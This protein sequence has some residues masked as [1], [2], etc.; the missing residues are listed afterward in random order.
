M[1][2]E[3]EIRQVTRQHLAVMRARATYQDLGGKIRN[4]LADNAVYAFIEKAGISPYGHNVIVYW[5]EEEKSLLSTDEGLMIEV[6]VQVASAFQSDGR[7]T[8]SATPGGTVATAIHMGPY[9]KLTEA[10]AAIREWCRQDKRP[11]AGPNWEVYGH[12]NDDPGKLRTDV[13]YLLK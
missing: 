1:R 11:I 12:W 4:I 3:V 9:D 10:H 5:D 8:C 6:G 2:Y 7:V 13:F